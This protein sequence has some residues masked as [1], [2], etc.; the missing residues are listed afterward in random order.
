V[1]HRSSIEF[2]IQSSPVGKNSQ[3]HYYS[4]W[5]VCITCHGAAAH[6]LDAQNMACE[7]Y[8]LRI[9]FGDDMVVM[10]CV[11]GSRV[12]IL[13]KVLNPFLSYRACSAGWH[14]N[15]HTVCCKKITK[16]YKY[17]QSFSLVLFVPKF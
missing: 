8:S 6:C 17:K 16:E 1:S 7:I 3:Y 4:D 2:E 13:D 9:A 14:H 10:H 15:G 12:I 5:S 11:M